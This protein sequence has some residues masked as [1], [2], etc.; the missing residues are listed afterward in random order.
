MTSQ[1]EEVESNGQPGSGEPE[2]EHADRQRDFYDGDESASPIATPCR[3]RGIA[4]VEEG[5][6]AGGA[7]LSVAEAPS[8]AAPTD[9]AGAAAAP[10]SMTPP[11]SPP[12]QPPP[13]SPPT[14]RRRPSMTELMMQQ[15]TFQFQ[16]ESEM[17]D[18]QADVFRRMRFPCHADGS[19]MF[20]KKVRYNITYQM[21]ME[22]CP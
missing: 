3:K 9:E 22:A 16:S 6:G 1:P 20:V 17:S 19:A 4:H 2:E 15:M 11:G 10:A 18:A 14:F 5:G 21:T 8:A 7:E 13:G 12:P